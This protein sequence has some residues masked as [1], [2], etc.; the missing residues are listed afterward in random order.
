[1]GCVEGDC[2]NV[3][4]NEHLL[5]RV[6]GFECNSFVCVLCRAKNF[7]INRIEGD[8]WNLN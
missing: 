5:C 1:M 2:W 6:I 3:I 8:G 4:L 7:N